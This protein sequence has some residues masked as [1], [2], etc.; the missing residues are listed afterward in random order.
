MLNGFMFLNIDRHQDASFNFFENLLAGDDEKV[1]K[2]QKFYDEYRAVMDVPA[3]YFLDSI[4]YFQEHAL[5]LGKMKW[6]NHLI[7]PAKIKNAK[8]FT[9]EGEL[10][11]ISCPGQTEAAHAICSN[12]SDKNRKHYLQLGAGHYG[13]FSGSKWRQSIYPKIVDF[14][15]AW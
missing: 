14:C 3:Q 12:I 2:H 8:L 15:G 9:I 10:D 5:P 7:N 6:R 11:D 13:I 1:D 4:R